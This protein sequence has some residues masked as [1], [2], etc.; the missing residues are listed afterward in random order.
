MVG[1]QPSLY[2]R[3]SPVSSAQLVVETSGRFSIRWPNAG[4]WTL[5]GG[6][7]TPSTGFLSEDVGCLSSPC[8]HPSLKDILQLAAPQK[9]SLSPRAAAGILRRAER[10][11][12]ALPTHLE[13]ALVALT[14]TPAQPASPS[15]TS[16]ASNPVA[17]RSDGDTER[18]QCTRSNG[19]INTE[20]PL[21]LKPAMGTTGTQGREV[22]EPTTSSPLPSMPTQA[23]TEESMP[24]PKPLSVRRLTPTEDG[25]P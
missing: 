25:N 9:Y 10:R 18:G 22:T 17:Q 15:K 23:Q 3:M 12:R 1:F 7:S 2:S 8:S 21:P 6:L 5:H 4:Q 24:N 13:A 14:N 16:A 20:S 11:G 19:A